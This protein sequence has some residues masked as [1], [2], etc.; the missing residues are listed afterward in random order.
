MQF[1]IDQSNV[2]WRRAV[3][4]S[5][6]AAQ[7]AANQTNVQ[8]RFNMS[9]VSQNNLWQ[10]WRDEA[11]WLFQ[12]SEREIDRQYNIA[13]SATNREAAADAAA[14]AQKAQLYQQLG[15]FALNLLF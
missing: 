15:S 1:A 3:N 7:N 10:A 5:N 4:E 11:S 6:T 9:Q 12:S 8:N 2:L 13:M 14:D